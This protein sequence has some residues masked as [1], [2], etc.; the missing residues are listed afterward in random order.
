MSLK[1]LVSFLFLVTAQL[2]SHPLPYEIIEDRCAL[3]I[4]NPSFAQRR[5]AKLR[6][7]NG[8]EAYL[9]SDPSIEESAAALAV[10]AG[11]WQDP[12]EYPGMAHFLEHM[13]FMG[14]ATYPKEFEYMQYVFDNGGKVNA[15]TAPD[16]TVYIFSVNNEAF[17][18]SLNRFSHFFIDPLFLPSCIERELL[19]VDQEHSKNLEND[20]WRQY[21]I[22]KETGNPDHPNAKF[23]TG[24]A[25]TLKDIPQEVMK[26]W[27]SKHYQAN[28]MHLAILSSLPLEELIQVTLQDFSPV[29]NTE[30]SKIVTPAFPISSQKQKGNIIYVKP[31]KDLKMLSLSWEIPFSYSQDI[32]VK[33]G[34][35]IAYTLQMGNKTGLLNL[36]KRKHLA[37]KIHVSKEQL[38]KRN[39]LFSI[40]IELTDQGIQSVDEVIT[41]CFEALARLKK[42]GIP[43]YIFEE[44]KKIQ[45]IKYQYQSRMDAFEFVEENA[46][47]LVDE[48]LE[49]FPLKT[50]IPQKYDPKFI[51]AYLQ[52]L[53]PESCI[54][55]V[56]AD[57]SK[58][59]ILPNIKEKWMDAEY[60]IRPISQ[61][62]LSV[63]TEAN[64]NPQITLPLPNPYIPNSLQL[65]HQI[66]STQSV[67][68]ILLQ[69]DSSA[70]I[71][72]AEDQLYLTPEISHTFR[73]KSPLLNGTPKSK[74]LTDFYLK[75]I[76]DILSPTITAANAAGLKVQL[77]QNNL[78]FTINIIGYS[79]K[80][81]KFTEELF[82]EI[83]KLSPTQEQF[84]IYKQS[85]ASHYEN[86]QK[87]L[88]VIQSLDVLNNAIFSTHPMSQ[89]KLAVLSTIH[90]ED[91]INF[92]R[93]LFK[94]S[95]VEG[96]IYGNLHRQ[97]AEKLWVS[98]KETIKNESYSLDEQLSRKILILSEGNGPYMLVH[99]TPMKGNAAVLVIEQ[100][101]YSFTKRAAQQVLGKV[102]KDDF[103]DT[104]RTK[105]QT[106]YIAKAWEIEEE[107]QLLQFFAVQ[108]STHKPDDLIARFELFLENFLKQ[109]TSKV[110]VE[111]FENVRKMM[112]TTLQM[113]PENITL[114]GLQLFNLAFDFEGDFQWIEKR[115]DALKN[116]SYE[117]TRFA[118]HQFFSRLNTR[119]LASLVEGA[120]S[121]ENDFHY[122]VVT[123]D[124]L[125]HQGTF[126]AWK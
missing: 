36:L 53:S 101:G 83:I 107:R 3:K 68:P 88:P 79:D 84:E 74:V 63:W 64:I 91:C 115:I 77:F 89:E 16:K 49:T 45:E 24:N 48:P 104:L 10:E 60:T 27:Y 40:E 20:G 87:E 8:L 19:A 61:K 33:A 2:L 109:F 31:V 113:P 7:A 55:F 90:Y 29:A 116:L 103:F 67:N 22:F 39:E 14:T 93:N 21:M 28:K 54:Y 15:Y 23:S 122:E 85:L 58:T 18:G 82:K 123:K 41:H 98:I 86:S 57:P 6:L 118:A 105:Q 13:L 66:A 75:T 81:S 117:E 114:K 80:S 94:K 112:I 69:E 111:R 119:R 17:K 62:Q 59:N 120:S 43:K 71:Y 124:D 73:I 125:Q 106:A 38:G 92:S 37:E 72:Y 70:K 108:S 46:R 1:I 110:S 32:E 76:Y 42:T 25:Q 35:L 126:F 47:Q 4:E 121:K 51:T 102:L 78:D 56:L 9:I 34:D 97:E 12:P 100:G 99:S 44:V 5:T 50:K 65:I 30:N 11:S 26:K 95:Y 96:F 52:S